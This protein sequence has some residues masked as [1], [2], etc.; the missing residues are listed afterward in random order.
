VGKNRFELQNKVVNG[1]REMQRKRQMAKDMKQ[2]NRV[3]RRYVSM[4][5][6]LMCNVCKKYSYEKS[7]PR[8]KGLD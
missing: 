8:V 7:Y 1:D 6:D 2:S 5:D 4:C 3:S